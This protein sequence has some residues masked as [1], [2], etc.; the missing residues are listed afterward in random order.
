MELCQKT[1]KYYF[2][3]EVELDLDGDGVKEPV[4]YPAIHGE[5][6]V[7]KSP[8]LEALKELPL[9][10]TYPS[11]SNNT[12]ATWK[13]KVSDI[14]KTLEL[15][16]NYT[17]N[18]ENSVKYASKEDFKIKRNWKCF[19]DISKD[20]GLTFEH[21]NF[22]IRPKKN[23]KPVSMIQ[24]TL[25][26]DEKGIHMFIRTNMGHI[27]RSDSKD[28]GMTWCKAYET[29]MGNPNSGIDVVKLDNGVLVLIMNP[30]SENWGDRAPLVLMY[31]TYFYV[32]VKF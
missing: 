13:Y 3:Y 11:V 6:I 31:Y 22:V 10:E 29:P 15:A 24:P 27:Y 7:L 26:E 5:D 32:F 18:F 2:T 21:S 8:D 30:I 14:D 25:W 16:H 20:D 9:Y 17:N 28:G 19:V 12:S 1:N 4:N 23:L